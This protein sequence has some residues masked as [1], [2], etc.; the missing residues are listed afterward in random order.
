MSSQLNSNPEILLRK[1]RNA[2]RTRI[3][4]QELAKA[5]KNLNDKQKRLN[6]N[7]FIRIEKIVSTTLATEREKERVKR[8]SKLELKKSKNELDNLPSDRD[9]ILKITEKTKE[10]IAKEE[11]DGII[12]DDQEGD[13][14]IKEKTVY[15]GEETLLFVIRVRGPTAVKIPKKI[16]KVLSLLRLV[17]VNTG[18]FMKLSKSVFPLL[19]IISPYVI[20]GKP[21]LSSIRSLIQKRSRI[22]VERENETEPRAVIL[23]DNNV[24]E[25]KLGSEGVICMEDIIHEIATMGDAFQACNFFLLPFRLNREVS[26]F[27]AISRLNKL[28]EREAQSKLRQS[29]NSAIAPI[30]EV[31]IDSMISKLN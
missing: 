6:K 28:Q 4:K 25:E 27:S 22:L 14:L 15:N 23:N 29:S 16:F 2:D 12:T 8:I 24:V 17:D 9:F 11:E 18:V 20:I 7:K 19:K 13:L 1:R 26:G 5:K 31:D 3:E 21:S 30:I 10:Q